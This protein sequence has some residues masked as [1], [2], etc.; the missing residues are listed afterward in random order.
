MYKND[1]MGKGGGVQKLFTLT[2]PPKALSLLLKLLQFF[3]SVLS[4]LYITSGNF[5]IYD[6]FYPSPSPSYQFCT[7]ISHVTLTRTKYITSGLDGTMIIV[8]QTFLSGFNV[9]L[10]IYLSL[11]NPPT[12][13]NWRLYNLME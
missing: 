13:E 3:V 5:L 9:S 11:K 2:D 10:A 7:L 4:N 1:R 12:G 8:E 6:F